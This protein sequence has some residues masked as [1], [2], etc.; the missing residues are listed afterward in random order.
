MEDSHH[1]R[2]E[3]FLRL[4]D[5][6]DGH[7]D[8]PATTVWP[9]L[10]TN[11]NTVISELDG[12]AA[13]EASGRGSALEGTA[14][15]AAA[16]EALREDLEAISRTARAIAEDRPGFDSKFRLP[17]GNNDQELVDTGLGYAENAAPIA[18][19][20]I[21]RPYFSELWAAIDVTVRTVRY[22]VRG[23]VCIASTVPHRGP[24]V[25][26]GLRR[27]CPGGRIP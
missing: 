5:F 15:R 20:F 10:V 26:W 21:S 16:R 13:S 22:A 3:M 4:K 17:R 1:R 19:D 25:R 18:A 2:R 11:L 6:S 14:T 9:Q 7:T 24:G 23:P 8:I 12:H 27:D